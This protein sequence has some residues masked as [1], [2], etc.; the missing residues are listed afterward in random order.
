MT[1]ENFYA[2]INA[3]YEKHHSLQKPDQEAIESSLKE[4]LSN[5]NQSV[6]KLNFTNIVTIEDYFSLENQL[7]EFEATIVD[8]IEPKMMISRIEA[9]NH[10]YFRLFSFLAPP[11][12]EDELDYKLMEQSKF[13]DLTRFIVLVK[14][15]DDQI[16]SKI[17]DDL[18]A[19]KIPTFKNPK[20][21]IL[22]ETTYSREHFTLGKMLKFSGILVRKPKI[23]ITTENDD[24]CGFEKHGEFYS[25]NLLYSLVLLSFSKIENGDFNLQSTLTCPLTQQYFQ[26]LKLF[27]AR[28]IDVLNDE[29]SA[30][31]IVYSL[32]TPKTETS[33]Q[34]DLS[35]FNLNVFG[36][37]SN[38]AALLMNVFV[39]FEINNKIIEIS[40]KG[41]ATKLIAQKNNDYE[42]L[43]LN[44]LYPGLNDNICIDETSISIAK[45]NEVETTNIMTISQI[46]EN[47]IIYV[48]YFEKN[49]ISFHFSNPILILSNSRSVFNVKIKI[50][51]EES[52]HE[53]QNL[54]GDENELK[55]LGIKNAINMMR[56]WV[57][58]CVIK[59]TDTCLIQTDFVETRKQ[60]KNLNADGFSFLLVLAKYICA[61]DGKNQIEFEHYLKAKSIME[62]VAEREKR[63]LKKKMNN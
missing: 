2:Q 5:N 54:F 57:S 31:L 25:S 63:Y 52:P 9:N 41:L 37:D 20:I 62:E 60:N 4:Y 51:L 8:V 50:H 12:E 46:V 49:F 39:E 6:K 53:K 48:K 22:I 3:N 13:I 61:E 10:N 7:V 40:S 38:R 23:E 47:Q 16:S 30:K 18:S 17:W 56:R 28:L 59:E 27:E 33:N 14:P 29:L 55:Q 36:L 24:N 44:Q 19:N 11:A 45:L 34:A 43:E 35:F 15:I 42:V 32:L 58:A 1:C 26:L 21:P